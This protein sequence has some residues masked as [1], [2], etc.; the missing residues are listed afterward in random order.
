MAHVSIPYTNG[1]TRL[2]TL[3]R[4]ARLVAEGRAVYTPA[5]EQVIADA[6]EA[7]AAVA[8]EQPAPPASRKVRR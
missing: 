6:P 1:N 5:P 3:A 7:S 4:A 8:P 2:I